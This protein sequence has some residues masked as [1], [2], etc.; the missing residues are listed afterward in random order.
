MNE[1]ADGI[2]S[3]RKT[4]I[5]QCQQNHTVSG[6][7]LLG[8]P[9]CTIVPENRLEPDRVIFITPGRSADLFF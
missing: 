6:T 5:K 1:S 2:L 3:D 8:T 4:T 9:G 7:E